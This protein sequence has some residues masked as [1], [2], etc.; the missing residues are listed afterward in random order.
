MIFLRPYWLILLIMPF[1]FFWFQRKGSTQN[2]WRQYIAPALMPYLSV[3]SKVGGGKSRRLWLLTL[4]WSLLVIGMA[5]PAFD[6]WPTPTID[7]APATVLIVDL[8]TLNPEKTTQLH[9]KLYDLVEQLKDNQIGLVLYDTKGYVALPL[10]RDTEILNGLIP[11]LQSTV[12][13]AIGNDVIKGFEKADE[14]F[15]NTQRKSGRILLITGGTPDVQRA[16]PIIKKM[17]YQ[18]GVLG[19]G[20]EK[21]GEPITNRNGT[22]VRDSN[23]QLVLSRPDK[24]ELSL[25]GTYYAATPAGNEIKALINSTTPSETILSNPNMPDFATSLLQADVWRDLGFYLVCAT[26]PFLALLFRK[27]VF[28]GL[29]ITLVCSASNNGFA[30]SWW[31]R[32]DQESYRAVQA[33]NE[34]YR[35]QNYQQALSLYETDKTTEALYNKANALAQLGQYQTAID[36]YAELLKQNPNHVDG[37]YNKEYLEK[38][39]QPPQNQQNEQENNKDEQSQSN[40]NNQSEQNEQQP[41][42]ENQSDSTDSSDSPDNKQSDS[43]DSNSDT[44]EQ[45]GQDKQEPE[46]SEITPQNAPAGDK[47]QQNPESNESEKTDT[48]ETTAG[49]STSDTKDTPEQ[50]GNTFDTADETTQSDTTDTQVAV[51]DEEKASDEPDQETQQILNRLKKDPARVLRYRLYRQHQGY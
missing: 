34:A 43:T 8:N 13:P 30:A 6:K 31:L 38:Q 14:L 24:K 2:P 19:I 5:G 11:S 22:F 27:G 10:T 29:V 35:Q 42:Q 37:A 48:S 47:E 26:L 49:E 41:Q 4:I 23:G 15:K 12:M 40:Q 16:L 18:I 36:T 46:Q 3:S 21:T 33:G 7:E 20:D 50:Q 28:F 1:L 39:L 44:T 45:S 25:L 9:L 51:G 17:P 32:P